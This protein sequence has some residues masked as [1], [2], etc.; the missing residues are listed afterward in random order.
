MEDILQKLANLQ[1]IDTRIDELKQLRG[2]LP[3]EVLDIE[4]D[5]ARQ[6]MRLGKLEQERR[7][8]EVE[9][10]NLALEISS[11]NEKVE[12]YEEQ[13]LAVR[14]RRE[15]DALR[16]ETEPQKQLVEECAWRIEKMQK[17]QEEIGPEIEEMSERL[18]E[19]R[20]LHSETKENRDKGVETAQS[21]EDALLE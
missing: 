20:Q 16:K 11:A 7:D 18:T 15:D 6:E 21:E 9:L 4:T 14:T 10:K 8:L 17:G 3:E 12:K 5:I 13:Q 2:D 19:V 1:Y